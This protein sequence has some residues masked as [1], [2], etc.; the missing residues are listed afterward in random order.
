MTVAFELDPQAVGYIV[1][2]RWW[3]I[4]YDEAQ[5]LRSPVYGYRWPSQE[6]LISTSEPAAYAYDPTD[7]GNPGPRGIHGQRQS[8][9][10]LWNDPGHVG[11]AVALWGKTVEGIYGY[12]AEFA[13]PLSLE[14]H[15]CGGYGSAAR[16]AWDFD[17][18]SGRQYH[19]P[20]REGLADCVQHLRNEYEMEA[21]VWRTL[22]PSLGK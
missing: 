13:Y 16:L 9:I 20:F 15:I 10:Y 21:D 3:N 19:G 14:A 11:G 17:D 6:P 22:V 7:G 12:Q 1:G 18:C 8:E 2:F 4:R 5:M